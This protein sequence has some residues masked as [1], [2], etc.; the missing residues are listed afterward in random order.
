MFL[1]FEVQLG[2]GMQGCMAS[3]CAPVEYV[4]QGRSWLSH[5]GF[6]KFS[7]LARYLYWPRCWEP[8][9]AHSH[10]Q[11]VLRGHVTAI[12]GAACHKEQGESSD[13]SASKMANGQA[14]HPASALDLPSTFSMCT[15]QATN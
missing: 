6:D 9:G 13:H 4:C 3:G 5:C 2:C 1:L 8:P 11:A 15:K 12:Q 14:E 7:V 10:L